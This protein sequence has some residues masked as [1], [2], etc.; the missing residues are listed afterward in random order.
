MES[1][2]REEN[3]REGEKERKQMVNQP[4]INEGMQ[5]KRNKKKQKGKL[6]VFTWHAPKASKTHKLCI[7][8]L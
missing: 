4:M 6:I 8:L 3:I 2:Y 5:K 7:V 1:Q